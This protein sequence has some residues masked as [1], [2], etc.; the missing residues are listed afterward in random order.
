MCPNY[1]KMSISMPEKIVKEIDELSEKNKSSRSEIITKLAEFG[2]RKIS[3]VDSLEPMDIQLQFAK[4]GI[5]EFKLDF[6]DEVIFKTPKG[7]IV[8]SSMS[9]EDYIDIMPLKRNG[10]FQYVSLWNAVPN[11]E[12]SRIGKFAASATLVCISLE[13][14]QRNEDIESLY[15]PKKE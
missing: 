12:L 14:T 8:L 9:T 1:E 4:S 10:A 15:H 11:K 2:L 3:S 6:D 13:T 5:H 7:G